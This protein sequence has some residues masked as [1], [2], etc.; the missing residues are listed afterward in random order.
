LALA[1]SFALLTT[2]DA[3]SH[4][5]APLIAQDVVADNTDL[6]AFVAPDAPDSVTLISNWYGFQEPGGGPNYYRFGDDILYS[7]Y[8]DN[9][10]DAV[11]DVTYEFRFT[12]RIMDG[13]RYLYATGPITSADDFAQPIDDNSVDPAE[14]GLNITQHYSVTKVADGKREVIARDLLTPPANV[15]PR[16]IGADYEDIAQQAIHELDDGTKVFAGQREEGFYADIA[17]IFDLGGLRPFNELHAIPLPNADGVDTFAGYNVQ[18]IA[19]QIPKDELTADGDPVIGVWS[20]SARRKVEVLRTATNPALVNPD[21]TGEFGAAVPLSRGP[22]VQVSRLG[23]PLVNEVVVPLQFKDLYNSLEPRNDAAVFTQA[24]ASPLATEGPIPLVTDP[25][26]AEEIELLYGLETPPPPRDDLVQIYL[27]GIPGVNQPAGD[28]QPADLLRLNTSVE[29][30]AFGEQSPLGFLGGDADGFPNGRRPIDDVID[31]SLKAVA[32]AT[33]L[34]PDFNTEPNSLLGDGVDANDRE[35]LDKFPYLATPWQGYDLENP[36]RVPEEGTH[37][38]TVTVE[39]VSTPGLVDT[40]RADGTVPLSP[41]AYV[42]FEGG[43]PAFTPG[44]P[45]DSGTMLIAEDGFPAPAPFISEK[46]EVEILRDIESALEVGTF[47]APGGTPDV[48][49]IFSGE[50]ATFTFDASE[51]QRLQLETMFVQSNDWFYGFGNGGLEL[52]PGGEP[53]SGEVTSQLAVYDAGTEIDAPP[54]QGPTEAPGAV[55]KPVQDP[56]ATDVGDDENETVQLARDRHPDFE[57]PENSEVIRVTVTS[58][59]R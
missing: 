57:I 44:K 42:A 34:T 38:F 9:D 35:F 1:L 19:L 47:A 31:I 3:S 33:P 16:T 58:Q 10:G 15:G 4:R 59:P 32:G 13:D 23:N 50:T 45:A 37:T 24:Q 25:I 36:D 27:T 18:S 46:T 26:L 53:I 48:P 40:D 52:F 5:E 29:P 21:D 51:G 7:V 6:Y 49:A 2:A 56:T 12:T 17:A 28:V 8:V 11:Q 54:G 20:E 30:T 43:D 22:W 39:N 41:G 14:G 55:Q